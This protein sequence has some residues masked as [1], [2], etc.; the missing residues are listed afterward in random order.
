M[1]KRKKKRKKTK[2]KQKEIIFLFDR[3]FLG[4]GADMMA[5]ASVLVESTQPMGL[6]FTNGE[7]T[8]FVAPVFGSTEANSTQI[9]TP[10]SKL[11]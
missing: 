6:Q 4:I 2:R 5:N 11:D 8:A 1:G 7:F 3:N 10:E 9:V